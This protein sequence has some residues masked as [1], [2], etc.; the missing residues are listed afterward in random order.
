MID[1]G[2][3]PEGRADHDHVAGKLQHEFTGMMM[4]MITI[5]NADDDYSDDD[6]DYND[7]QVME[8]SLELAIW[9]HDR[10]GK[11]QDFLGGARYSG[12]CFKNLNLL[13]LFQV[14]PWVRS[15]PWSV[16]CVDGRDREGGFP[17]AADARQA[18]LLGGRMHRSQTQFG[19]SARSVKCQP[20]SPL[21]D[22]V[23]IIHPSRL[24]SVTR[25]LP[26]GALFVIWT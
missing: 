23:L 2:Q 10:I 9:D 24:H 15:A 19:H 5:N 26:L 3:H 11:T 13:L 25:D 22:A 6:N 21:L 1:D 14:Q 12:H 18:K 4:I 20:V 17:L 16:G 8:R 7:D